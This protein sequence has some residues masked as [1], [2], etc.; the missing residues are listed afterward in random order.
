MRQMTAVRFLS[1]ALYSCLS[2]GFSACSAGSQHSRN[3]TMTTVTAR[4]SDSANTS[5]FCMGRFLINAPLGSTISGGSYKYDFAAVEPVKRMSLDEFDKYVTRQEADLTATINRRTKQSMLLQSIRPDR[6]TAILVSWQVAASTAQVKIAG[7]RWAGDHRF[8]IEDTVDPGKR[9][10]GIDGMRD[11][12]ERV[13]PRADIYIPAEPGYCFAGGFIANERVLNEESQTDIDIGGHPDAFLS[14]WIY[15]LPS[16]KRDRPLLDR[17]AGMQQALG[18]LATSVQVL[19]KGN[20]EIGT[21]KGQEHLVAAPNSRGMRAHAFVWETQGDGTLD[22]PAIKI[23]LTTGHQDANGNPQKASLTDQ[24]AMK[25]WD[26]ILASL[27]LRPSG[28]PGSS[29]KRHFWR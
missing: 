11:A 25:L 4:T 8:L 16:H 29:G 22:N 20:R 15:P 3:L 1:I 10:R 28:A 21:Y 9:Q 26:E 19:R 6:A 18:N 7:Y 14:V 17:L 12:L 23:E 5:T 24:E 13:G 27:R 2:I